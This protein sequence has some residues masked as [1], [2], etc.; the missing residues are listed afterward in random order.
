[1]NSG[2]PNLTG[3]QE[4]MEE[5]FWSSFS[6][7][8]MVILKIFLLV[9]VIMALNNRNLLD[10]LKHSVQAKENAQEEAKQAFY[11]AQSRLKTNAS[12]EEQLAYYQQQASGLEI[13]LLRSR[14]EIEEARNVSITRNAEINR[15]QTLNKEQSD[16][17]VSSDKTLNELR[18]RYTGLIV[19]HER[20][21]SEMTVV[22]NSSVSKDIEL[23]RLRTKIDESDKRLL[24][25]EGDFAELDQKYQ[26]LLKPARSPKSKQVVEVIY[27]KT[28]YSIR[29]PGE[30]SYRNLDRA[31]LESELGALKTFFGNDLYVKIIIP[32][33]SGLSY[34]EGWGFT[35]NILSRYDYYY[36]SNNNVPVGQAESPSP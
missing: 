31:T 11:L 22:R 23:S 18:V 20:I 25:M 7:V 10:D 1:M 15:L 36:Q 30:G 24:S 5:G 29:K 34:S 21:Q 14:A 2:F 6:N 27:Q 35:S 4:D 17:I 12:L 28:G 33:N 3:G 16:A 9:M 8:M 19:E 13:E 32:D 26:K